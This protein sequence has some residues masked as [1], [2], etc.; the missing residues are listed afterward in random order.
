VPSNSIWPFFY[1]LII[2][3]LGA[4]WNFDI[5]LEKCNVVR[6]HTN[7]NYLHKWFTKLCNYLFVIL[8]SLAIY[9][10]TF[11]GK[12]ISKAFTLILLML[13][14]LVHLYSWQHLL[15]RRAATFRAQEVSNM[16]NHFIWTPPRVRKTRLSSSRQFVPMSWHW[17]RGEKS[18]RIR[19]EC[20]EWFISI[21]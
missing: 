18:D 11:N 17:I 2:T 3:K 8:V 7:G 10:E 6:I 20:I 19:E 16:G 21:V 13:I 9:T 4:V 5:L 14:K 1:T 15:T 12:Y